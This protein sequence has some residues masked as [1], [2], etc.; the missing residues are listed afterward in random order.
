MSVYFKDKFV[1]KQ[2]HFRMGKLSSVCTTPNVLANLVLTVA[3]NGAF[4]VPLWKQGQIYAAL[5][6]KWFCKQTVSWKLYERFKPE[7][8][9][10]PCK[11]LTTRIFQMKQTLGQP[12]TLLEPNLA[13][14][15][16]FWQMECS[17]M[18]LDSS[19]Y[20]YTGLSLI[21]T[22]HQ[23]QI[24]GNTY[25]TKTTQKFFISISNRKP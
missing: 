25:I 18:G 2:E 20:L 15:P 4:T 7:D 16:L 12:S 8:L 10:A 21:G 1:K 11:Y 5:Q 22:Q 13:K 19:K 24:F 6:T 14:L 17:E 3:S 23:T 9:G